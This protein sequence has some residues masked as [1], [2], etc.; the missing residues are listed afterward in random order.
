[1]QCLKCGSTERFKNGFY[2]GQQKWKCKSCGHTSCR[3]TPRGAPIE[4]IRLA[5]TLVLEG[6]GFNAT[7]RVLTAFGYKCSENAVIGWVRK[8][9][10]KA[11]TLD[12]ATKPTVRYVQIDEMFSY[13]KKRTTSD[14]SGWLLMAIPDENSPRELVIVPP[15]RCAG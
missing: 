7:A 11:H 15:K 14:F 4:M 9:G 13:V 2:Q 8:F 6:M 3:V 12:S 1:M 10:A 5:L